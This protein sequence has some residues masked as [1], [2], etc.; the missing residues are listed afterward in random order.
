[1]VMFFEYDSNERFQWLVSWLLILSS[2]T[3]LQREDK[4]LLHNLP[5][6]GLR[7]GWFPHLKTKSSRDKSQLLMMIL[8]QIAHLY[9][10]GA[11]PCIEHNAESTD[12]KDADCSY[13]YYKLGSRSCTKVRKRCFFDLVITQEPSLRRFGAANGVCFESQDKWGVGKF[14][15]YLSRVLSFVA[16]SLPVLSLYRENCSSQRDPMVILFLAFSS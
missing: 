6:K 14:P 5:L 2:F 1:M 3:L 16:L 13:L 9:Y 15:S 8:K 12:C 4:V 11:R 7:N 10:S